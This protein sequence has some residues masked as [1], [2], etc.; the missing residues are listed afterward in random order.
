MTFIYTI[1]LAASFFG[2]S[3]LTVSLFAKL[4]EFVMEEEK[5]AYNKL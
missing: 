3:Y 2:V 1:L 5:R 4:A